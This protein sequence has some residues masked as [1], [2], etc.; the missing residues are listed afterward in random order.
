[1]VGLGAGSRKTVF[2]G[3]LPIHLFRQMYRLG[4]PTIGQ[5]D[6]QTVSCQ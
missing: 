1:M 5:T 4:R 3:A 2:L 6:R